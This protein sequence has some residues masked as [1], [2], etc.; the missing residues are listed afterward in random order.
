MGKVIGFSKLPSY[1]ASIQSTFSEEKKVTFLD[2]NILVSSSYELRDSHEEVT[3]ALDLL[4]EQG[5]RLLAT[6]NTK[7]EFLEF[8][9]RVQ[10]TESLVDLTDEFSS[11]KLPQSARAKISTLKGSINTAIK[12]DQ[13]RDFIFNDFH[14][15]KIKKEFSAGDHS[16]RIGWLEICDTFLAGRLQI[17]AQNLEDRGVEYISQHNQSQARLFHK[18]IDWPDAMRISERTGA[19][20]S[21]SMILN[22]FQ[23]SHCPFIVSMDFDIGYAVLAD[24]QLKDAVMPDRI[25]SEYRHY[26]F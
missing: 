20:F 22:A 25:A 26:H 11:V 24:S 7:S 21:D 9:R 5:Y 13:E 4:V 2:T 6:V 14:L 1:L 12:A 15:K 18:K 8:Q 23:C 10:L 17:A 19:S 3:G 16:G